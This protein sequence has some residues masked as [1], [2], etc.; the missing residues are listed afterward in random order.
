MSAK[1]MT[2]KARREEVEALIQG[3]IA[4]KNALIAAL[5]SLTDFKRAIKSD[6]ERIKACKK[7]A[8]ELEKLCCDYTKAHVKH[9]FGEE[10]TDLPTGSLNADLVID[11]FK[12]HFINGY[13]GLARLDPTQLMT[14]QFIAGL[15]SEYVKTKLEVDER[16]I[17]KDCPENADLEHLG[18]KYKEYAKWEEA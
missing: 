6:E 12:Y 7:V 1:S 18:L 11:S 15:P 16:A 9:V 10:Y 17:T 5:P 8:A 3:G 14:Q 13:K 4:S 2:M